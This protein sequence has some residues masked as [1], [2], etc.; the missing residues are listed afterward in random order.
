MDAIPY[1]TIQLSFKYK[2]FGFYHS[3]LLTCNKENSN[4]SWIYFH[5]SKQFSKAGGPSWQW[6]YDTM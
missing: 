2:C 6:S 3:K 5:Q 4:K 1:K